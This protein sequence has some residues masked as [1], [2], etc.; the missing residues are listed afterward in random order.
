MDQVRQEVGPH[1]DPDLQRVLGE[2]VSAAYS[3]VPLFVMTRS[4]WTLI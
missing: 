2:T 4:L 1:L 3:T